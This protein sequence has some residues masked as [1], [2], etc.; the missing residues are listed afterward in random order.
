MQTCCK[1]ITFLKIKIIHLVMH[2]TAESHTVIV[3]IEQNVSI[4]TDA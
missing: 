2:L 4:T 3:Q 1:V